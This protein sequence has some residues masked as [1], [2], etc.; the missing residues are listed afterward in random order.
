VVAKDRV[1]FFPEH[2]HSCG[3]C[4]I[5]CPAGAVAEKE[6]EIGTVTVRSISPALQLVTGTLNEGEVLA[7]TVIREAKDHAG[8]V[9]W[10]ILDASPGTSCPVVETL[11]GS[12]FCIL[13][14]ESTPFGLHDLALAYEVTSGLGIPSGVVI[15]RSDGK[16]ESTRAFCSEHDLPILLVIPFERK[17][18]EIQG[19]G[20]LIA[21]VDP[22]WKER[23]CELAKA[24]RMLREAT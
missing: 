2:C 3:G 13:V 19:S 5:S 21:R 12:E 17:I 16:D 10:V 22:E 1:L 11:H 4:A 15:N 7:V 18:A 9:E 20:E 23:F 8:N 24:C 14:T 6:R